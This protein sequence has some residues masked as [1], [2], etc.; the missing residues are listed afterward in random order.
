MQKLTT[1][2]YATAEAVGRHEEFD[3]HGAL[4]ARTGPRGIGSGRL[5]QAEAAQFWT[6]HPDIVYVVAS[7]ATP[8]AWVVRGG[9]V[10]VVGQKFSVTSTKHQ[11]N[12]YLL[13]AQA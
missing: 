4:Y 8:I 7:Y 6:D 5:N 10:H 11:G 13:A 3:T 9:R 2:G 12:L 1:R